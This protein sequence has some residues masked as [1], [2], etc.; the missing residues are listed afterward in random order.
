MLYAGFGLIIIALFLKWTMSGMDDIIAGMPSE[1][2]EEWYEHVKE[3]GGMSLEEYTAWFEQKDHF[4]QMDK[5]EQIISEL[6]VPLDMLEGDFEYHERWTGDPASGMDAVR[7]IDEVI[8]KLVEIGD[9]RAVEPLIILAK[10]RETFRSESAIEALG[11]FDDKRS[12]DYLVKSLS[13]K[14]KDIRKT[15][16]D[17]LDKLGWDPE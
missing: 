11:N 15:A 6:N 17:A 14:E 9:V 12:I 3:G 7:R 8:D 4:N 10:K 1:A 13:D 5:V 16:A 2:Q